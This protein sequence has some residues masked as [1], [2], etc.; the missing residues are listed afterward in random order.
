MLIAGALHRFTDVVAG[1][2]HGQKLSRRELDVQMVAVPAWRSVPETHAPEVQLYEPILHQAATCRA[3]IGRVRVA[4]A[5]YV[6]ERPIVGEG[7]L[8]DS[9]PV[10][11]RGR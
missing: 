5:L 1:E 4:V 9:P 10:G 8:R 3:E 11:A 2:R 6:M 7:P